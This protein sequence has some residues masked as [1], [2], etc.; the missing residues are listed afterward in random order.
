[1]HNALL[2]KPHTLYCGWTLLAMFY[3]ECAGIIFGDASPS[4]HVPE[5]SALRLYT[6]QADREESSDGPWWCLPFLYFLVQKEG[7]E[8]E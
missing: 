8:R 7:K 3:P 2:E 1:M 6:R 5:F 4:Q